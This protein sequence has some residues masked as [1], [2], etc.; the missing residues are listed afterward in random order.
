M[1]NDGLTVY[2]EYP[3]SFKENRECYNIAT[4]WQHVQSGYIKA[5]TVKLN[6]S[7]ALAALQPQLERSRQLNQFFGEG[8]A[9]WRDGVENGLETAINL[10]LNKH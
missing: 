3:F 7:E 2:G 10:L 8:E 5:D 9:R 1:V 4:F 6:T